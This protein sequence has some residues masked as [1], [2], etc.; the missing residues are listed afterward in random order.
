MRILVL[1]ASGLTGKA[2]VKELQNENEVYG[3]YFHQKDEFSNY[4]NMVYLDAGD[5][6]NIRDIL[7]KIEPNIIISSMR[8]EFEKQIQL[9]KIVS[10]YLLN[11]KDGKLI[12]LSSANAFDNSVETPHYESDVPNAESAYGI[13]KVSCEKMLI[14]MLNEKAI[15]IR[16]PF[17]WS[18]HAPRFLKIKEQISEGKPIKCYRNLY[19]NHTTH[20]HIAHSIHAIINNGFSGIFHIGSKDIIEYKDFIGKLLIKMKCSNYDIE[21]EQ[22]PECKYF[23]AMSSNRNELEKDLTITID[24]IIDYLTM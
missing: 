7:V 23:L 5:L 18:K 15:I 19:S 21:L 12:Y 13:F 17:I 24:D 20:I 6:N 14:D 8:G 9:H 1:G 3:T 16:V 22:E 11:K 2:I 4:K 10:Q